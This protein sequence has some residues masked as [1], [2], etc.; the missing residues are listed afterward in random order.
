MA[1]VRL[2]RVGQRDGDGAGLTLPPE[3]ATELVAKGAFAVGGW[4]LGAPG[5]A[6]PGGPARDAS[7]KVGCRE[8][9]FK[10]EL[11]LNGSVK[12]SAWFRTT[13]KSEFSGH[14]AYLQR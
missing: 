7:G 9:R 12:N 4:L 10:H 1:R 5:P 2:D 11:I 8:T 14:L 3:L 6:P 13:P